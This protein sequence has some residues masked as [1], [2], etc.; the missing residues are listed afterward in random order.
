MGER[1]QTRFCV[2]VINFQAIL[3]KRPIVL[4][5]AKPSVHHFVLLV[6]AGASAPISVLI[7]R[8]PPPIPH[9]KIDAEQKHLPGPEVV[10]QAE[11]EQHR[12]NRFWLPGQL[13]ARL[14][15]APASPFALEKLPTWGQGRFSAKSPN[16]RTGRDTE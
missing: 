10:E 1:P 6:V 7:E 11:A 13:D 15:V 8:I 9:A 2:A 3:T 4:H 14:V 12:A 16:I 5:L